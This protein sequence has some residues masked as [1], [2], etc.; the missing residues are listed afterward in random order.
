MHLKID[1]LLL[2]VVCVGYAVTEDA[3]DPTASTERPPPTSPTSVHA[4]TTAKES[5]SS[6]AKTSASS[7]V[8]S[9]QS[10]AHETSTHAHV[11]TTSKPSDLWSFQQNGSYC[12]LVKAAISIEFKYQSTVTHQ[13][14]T[15]KIS[16]PSPQNTT[17]H[18]SCGANSQWIEIGF[19]DDWK[20]MLVFK[21]T[22][23]SKSYN[24]SEVHLT[25]NFTNGHIPDAPKNIS[26]ENG[27]SDPRFTTSKAGYLCM[28][29]TKLYDNSTVE[30][31]LLAIY[32]EQLRLE[33]FQA[34]KE[35]I[36]SEQY[37]RCKEDTI[38]NLVPIIVGACL[39]GLI[40]VVLVAYLIGR[41][42]SRRGYESV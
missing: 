40:I 26:G 32:T 39:G 29:R 22:N 15:S 35:P 34:K 12:I 23:D 25:W 33:A 1:L 28:A 36:F 2:V 19:F 42:R 13:T 38:S 21:Q 16:V 31:G 41:K 30:N 24:M 37:E 27:N 4:S 7:T 6:A 20:L 11:S 10:T 5:T 17:V 9:S 18:G 8:V 3:V 14:N